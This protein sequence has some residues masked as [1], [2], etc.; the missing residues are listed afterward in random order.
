MPC[1]LVGT[2]RKNTTYIF[3]PDDEEIKFFQNGVL[4]WS[5]HGIAT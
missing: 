5:P 3:E 1:E 2:V 4:T